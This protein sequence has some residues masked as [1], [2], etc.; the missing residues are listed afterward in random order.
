MRPSRRWG[1]EL[2]DRELQLAGPVGAR[3]LQLADEGLRTHVPVSSEPGS[4]ESLLRAALLLSTQHLP[5]HI[6][7]CMWLAFLTPTPIV[8]C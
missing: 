1:R 5:L 8:G 4:H 7:A 3:S 6:A 2:P